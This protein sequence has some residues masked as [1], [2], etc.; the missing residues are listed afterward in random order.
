MSM[1]R[2]EDEA[3]RL[4]ANLHCRQHIGFVNGFRSARLDLRRGG[5]AALRE[6]LLTW[7]PVEHYGVPVSDEYDV[8]FRAGMQRALEL[9][10]TGE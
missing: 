8:G 3:E 1:K 4:Y 10:L 5:E 9:Y 2:V 6:V 7:R